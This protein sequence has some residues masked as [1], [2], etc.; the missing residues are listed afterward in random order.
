MG[1]A[2]D[3]ALACD[4]RL[5]TPALQVQ[6][7]ACRIGLPLY[8]GALKR[9]CARMGLSCA[10]EVLL[11][12]ARL[13]AEMLAA[14]GFVHALVPAE[15]LRDRVLQRAV[16]IAGWPPAPLQ[17]M[18][19]VMLGLGAQVSALD[20]VRLAAALDAHEVARRVAALRPPKAGQA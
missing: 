9:W 16:E 10:M 6:V 14:R 20:R 17:A 15:E 19:Q 2:S 12:G 8:A 5:G 7:P 11:G 1:G 13:D 4:L 3:L 18:K